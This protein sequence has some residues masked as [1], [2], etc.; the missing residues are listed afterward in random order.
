LSQA[1]SEV[2][3]KHP[4]TLINDERQPTL[5]ASVATTALVES[6]SDDHK[7]PTQVAEVADNKQE[8]E[9]C[10][11]INDKDVD[12][13]LHYLVQW[14]PTWVSA[15]QPENAMVLVAEYKKSKQKDEKRRGRLRTSKAGKEAIAGARAIDKGQKKRGQ[16]RPRKQV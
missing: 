9:I 8:W 5:Q 11:I 16:G 3:L 4:A 12:D 6:A 2:H 1:Q 10:G 13:E 7:I 15:S 14:T